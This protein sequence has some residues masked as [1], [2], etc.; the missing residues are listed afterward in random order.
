[1]PPSS[2]LLEKKILLLLLNLLFHIVLL[3][4]VGHVVPPSPCIVCTP[5]SQDVV[6]PDFLLVDRLGS[7]HC[8]SSAYVY[9]LMSGH[10]FLD[11]SQLF[12]AAGDGLF[13]SPPTSCL[14]NFVC[15]GWDVVAPNHSP[16]P[17]CYVHRAE[18][19]PAPKFI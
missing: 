18:G 4:G 19:L 3:L 10:G 13:C 5:L 2:K 9:I 8:G 16:A 12:A 6:S 11:S 7:D 1:M 14:F 15:L 17:S